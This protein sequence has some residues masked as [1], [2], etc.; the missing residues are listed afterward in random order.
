MGGPSQPVQQ[1][2]SQVGIYNGPIPREGPKCIPVALAFAT[3]NTYT[4]D[5]TLLWNRGAITELQAVYI[6]NSLNGSPVSLNVNGSNQ[7]ITAPPQSQGIYP[8][9]CP[10]PPKF[11]AQSAGGVNV[12]MQFLNVPVTCLTWS[13]VGTPF[14]FTGGN[15][16]V[17]SDAALDSTIAGGQVAVKIQK[18]NAMTDRSGTITAGGTAQA[19]AAANGAR[20]GLFVQ[21]PSANTGSLWITEQ[22]V[23]AVESEPSIEIPPGMAFEYPETAIPVTAISIIGATTGMGF[24]AREW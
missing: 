22:G 17:V 23:N 18:Q 10:N 8:I 4:I 20:N 19:L 1:T 21:N 2:Y 15:A 16:L 24:A 5:F 14:T 13:S 12:G 11:T 3:N 6:D 9:F 7:T